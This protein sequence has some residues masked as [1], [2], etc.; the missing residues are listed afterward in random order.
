MACLTSVVEIRGVVGR[1]GCPGR[2]AGCPWDILGRLPGQGAPANANAAIR[3]NSADML[4]GRQSHKSQPVK[5]GVVPV[6]GFN[7]AYLD[8]LVY[9]AYTTWWKDLQNWVEQ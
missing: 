5:F 2:P 3:R 7:N 8:Q 6:S 9:L 4:G 1:V